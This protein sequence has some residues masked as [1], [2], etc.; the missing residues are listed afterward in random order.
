MENEERASSNHDDIIT[1]EFP[2]RVPREEAPMK[3]I[4]PSF[5]PNFNDISSE[6]LDTF[7]F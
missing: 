1:F 6:Y 4:S 7:L 3:N 2:I 5:L